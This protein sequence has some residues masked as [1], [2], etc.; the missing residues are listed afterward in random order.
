MTLLPRRH[1]DGINGLAITGVGKTDGQ[2]GGVILGLRHSGGQWFV[3]GFGLDH[4][5]LGMAI[6]QH[7]VGR[8][9]LAALAVTLQP[10]Q[11]DGVFPANAAARSHPPASGHQHGVDMIAAG[12]G[13]VHLRLTC[14]TQKDLRLVFYDL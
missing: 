4:R 8:E 3:P 9:R 12:F 1:V 14:E 13:F 11:G 7:I 5:Q 2:L 6:L 10:P